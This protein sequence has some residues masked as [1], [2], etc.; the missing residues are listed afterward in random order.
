MSKKYQLNKTDLESLG[1]GLL[2]TLAGAFLT[3]LAQVSTQI[4]FGVYT[5]FVVAI[6][7]LV[8]NTGRKFLQGK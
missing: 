6:L 5:P 2:I 1:K 8:V 4:D 3:F 7:A